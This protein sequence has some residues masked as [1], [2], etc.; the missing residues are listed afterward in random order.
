MVGTFWVDDRFPF[1]GGNHG[2]GN[3]L[4]GRSCHLDDQKEAQAP[5]DA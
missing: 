1:L 2:L 3:L 5:S 4:A